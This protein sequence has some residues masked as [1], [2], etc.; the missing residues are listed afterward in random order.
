[1]NGYELD[2]LIYSM[3]AVQA[4]CKEDALETDRTPFT[5]SGVG[6]RFGTLLAQVDACARAI[7]ILATRERNLDA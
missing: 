7:E 2:G 6:E 1:M 4:D 3:R 5:P